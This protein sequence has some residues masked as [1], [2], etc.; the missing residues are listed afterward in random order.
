MPRRRF[1]ILATVGALL[2][3]SACATP[4]IADSVT[5][6]LP[7]GVEVDPLD[8]NPI[9]VWAEKNVR[10]AVVTWGSSSCP[11]V[12]SDLTVEDDDRIALTF[13]SSTNKPC[14]A[15]MAATTHE[16]TLPDEITKTPV[17]ITI[18]YQDAD[19]IDTLS[20]P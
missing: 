7:A 15:D 18:S 16:F 13:A 2:A 6:G 8:E 3:L 5:R 1:A 14:T 10:F 9:A 12:A 17:T 4:S 20:L 11:L 19:G